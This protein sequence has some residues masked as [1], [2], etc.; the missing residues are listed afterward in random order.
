MVDTL[1]FPEALALLEFWAGRKSREL[2]KAEKAALPSPNAVL[3]TPPQ[4]VIEAMKKHKPERV[5]ARA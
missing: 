1:P 4:Y 2:S 3:P 5:N